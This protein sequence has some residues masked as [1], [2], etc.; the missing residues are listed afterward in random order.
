MGPAHQDKPEPE[1]RGYRVF[2]A[3]NVDPSVL[4]LERVRE[5]V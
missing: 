4:Y 1:M 2:E 5:E 3:L